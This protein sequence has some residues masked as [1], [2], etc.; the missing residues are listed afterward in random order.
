VYSGAIH[1]NVKGVTGNTTLN[2]MSS[3]LCDMVE[4]VVVRVVLETGMDGM[5]VQQKQDTERKDEEGTENGYK[6]AKMSFNMMK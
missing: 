4:Q 6:K 2:T 5:S 3:I 1:I